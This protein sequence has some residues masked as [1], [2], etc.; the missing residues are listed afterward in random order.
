M[1]MIPFQL[2]AAQVGAIDSTAKT[3]ATLSTGLVRVPTL[4]ILYKPAGTAFT[5]ADDVRL[6]LKDDQGVIFFSI[7]ATGFLAVATEQKRVLRAGPMAFDTNNYLFKLSATGSVATATGAP[8][9]YGRLFYEE[10]A[11]TW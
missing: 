7:P 10:H 8:V 4:L 11:G 5:V 9:V 6:E 2:T 1:P 3:I